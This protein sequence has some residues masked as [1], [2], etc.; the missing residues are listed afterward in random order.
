LFGLSLQNDIAF[1]L[2]FS[3]SKNEPINYEFGSGVKVPVTGNGSSVTT[4]N[5]SI[6]Y[7]LSSKVS[8][9]L[10]YK[11]ISTKPTGTSVTTVPRSSN[12]GG[13]NIRITI[14]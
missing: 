13:L 2:T 3:N 7:S 6:Q 9:Q 11:Y 10:F 5:P 4:I 12:E 1:A 8:M 14:Q